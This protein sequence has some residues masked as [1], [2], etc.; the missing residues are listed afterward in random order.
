MT[1]EDADIVQDEKVF[2]ALEQEAMEMTSGA[3][4][5]FWIVM[6]YFAGTGTSYAIA[7]DFF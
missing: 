7:K 4:L 3:V 2:I 1:F 5:P 6:A